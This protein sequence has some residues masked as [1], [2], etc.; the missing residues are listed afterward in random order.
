MKDVRDILEFLFGQSNPWLIG[1]IIVGSTPFM[2]KVVHEVLA[3]F[4]S[5]KEKK[6]ALLLQYVDAGIEGKHAFA[7]EAVFHHYFGVKLRIA[8]IRHLLKRVSPLHAVQDFVLGRHFLV[9]DP[10]TGMVAFRKDYRLN[11]R[12]LVFFAAFVVGYVGTTMSAF[13]LIA[14]ISTGQSSSVLLSTTVILGGFALIWWFS[15]AGAQALGAAKRSVVSE[16]ARAVAAGLTDHPGAAAPSAT[17]ARCVAEM[18]QP[19]PT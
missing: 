9:L 13:F 8:E 11:L 14:S 17:K 3:S 15:I 7:V 12:E 1:A 16:S 4:Q 18:P 5:V 6:L 10:E 19:E 2:M